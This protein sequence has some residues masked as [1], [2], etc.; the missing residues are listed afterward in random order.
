MEIKIEKTPVPPKKTKYPFDELEN[1]GESFVVNCHAKLNKKVYQRLN[2]ACYIYSNANPG[3]KFS[4]R[5]E[6]DGVRVI[7]VKP[8]LSSNIEDDNN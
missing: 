7:R 8:V 2:S 6:K 3:K 1:I 4:V 5:K